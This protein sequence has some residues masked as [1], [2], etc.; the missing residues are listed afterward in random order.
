MKKISI[1]GAGNVGTSAA[2]YLAE[3]NLG[4]IQLVDVKEGLAGGKAMDLKQAAPLRHYDVDIRGSSDLDSIAGSQ[5]IVI[6]AGKVRKPGMRREDLLMENAAIIFGLTAAIKQQ[7][8]EAVVIAVT[9][10][11]DAM[12]YLLTKRSGLSPQ[13]V[14]GLTGVLDVTRFRYFI[15]EALGVDS[16]DVTAMI[17]G[18]HHENMVP[19]PKYTRVG[20]IPVTELMSKEQLREI[21]DKV[22]DAGAAIVDQLKEG[23]SHYTPG[24]CVAEMVEAILRDHK[25]IL[26][27]ATLLQ[28]EYG[29]NDI[30]LGV[31]ALI[32]RGGVEKII[33]LKLD[34][35]ERQLFR[36]SADV[37]TDSQKA[38]LQ[39]ENMTRALDLL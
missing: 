16:R 21:C 8:P 36:T 14:M 34:E 37:V 7:A 4:H 10:P 24:A 25:R 39:V 11:V 13:R 31:P 32:G 3:K 5:V 19:V 20:G 35:E 33:Q 6:A 27:V 26:P 9:E 29:L 2:L 17:I 30:C 1:I 28:G 15:S 12:T 23:S 38:V 22:R 18:G